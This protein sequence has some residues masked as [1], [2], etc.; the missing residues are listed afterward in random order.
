MCLDVKKIFSNRR[1]AQE[2]SKKPFIARKEIE[3]YKILQKSG[4][5]SLYKCFKYEKGWQ[6]FSKF[7]FNILKLG[8]KDWNLS[9]SE[10][11]HFFTNE[12]RAKRSIRNGG[13]HPSFYK[14]VKMYIPKGAKYFRGDNEDIVTNT[15]IYYK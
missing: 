15:I 1:E 13:A 3:V 14:I 10:G 2:F 5:L 6:Y 8:A 12:E 7:S 11:L 9:V 4:G